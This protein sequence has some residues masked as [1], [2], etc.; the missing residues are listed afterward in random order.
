MFLDLSKI[1]LT[2]DYDRVTVL[3]W[4]HFAF[5]ALGILSESFSNNRYF[6]GPL[7][8]ALLLSFY[9]Y[10]FKTVQKLYYTFWSFSAIIAITLLF[11]LATSDGPGAFY[12]YFLASICL[13]VEAYIL[14]SPIYY[15]LIRWWEYDFRFR[16]DIRASVEVDSKEIE[17]RIT[18]LRR[19]AGCVTMFKDLEV[20]KILN[21]KINNQEI[22]AE[23]MSRR[24]YSL[25]R[26]FIYGVRFGSKSDKEREFFQKFQKEWLEDLNKKK[27]M[28]LQRSVT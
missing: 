1:K 14:S 19:F 12:S 23:V 26:P 10:Y 21:I 15:Q 11:A 13:G 22:N 2:R 9:Y 7:K 24:S 8:I 4:L 18:D 27:K 16:E 20:G 3:H 28:K 5:I 6:I 17:I 25:G